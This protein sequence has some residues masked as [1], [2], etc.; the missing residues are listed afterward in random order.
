M[1]Y[2]KS[3]YHKMRYK[4]YVPHV[5]QIEVQTKVHWVLKQ[6]FRM[7]IRKN[8]MFKNRGLGT[9]KQKSILNTSL[10]AKG[11]L[12]HRLQRL[13]NPKWPPGGPKMADGVWKGV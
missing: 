6:S 2:I 5:P 4:N 10:A 9:K 13:K 12:A 1:G 3:M 11:A 8:F 7:K